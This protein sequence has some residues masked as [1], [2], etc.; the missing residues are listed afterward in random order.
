MDIILLRGIGDAGKTTTATMTY[1][2]LEKAADKKYLFDHFNNPI[3]EVK[4][5]NNGQ[6]IDF[7]AVLVIKGK[8]V[9]IIT[10]GDEVLKLLFNITF[11]ID[12]VKNH[13][14]VNIDILLCCGRSS[15]RNGSAFERLTNLYPKSKLSEVWVTRVEENIMKI[16]KQKA[17]NQI[18]SLL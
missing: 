12:F 4:Y 11:I 1:F 15:N 13:L 17:V 2:Q 16:E 9:V 6:I 14:K 10:A 5:D 7:K 18:I 8:V 3:D